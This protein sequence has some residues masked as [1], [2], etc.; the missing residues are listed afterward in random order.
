MKYYFCI[1]G[2]GL[3]NQSLA[4]TKKGATVKSVNSVTGA[5]IT[6][7]PIKS[8][9]QQQNT[10]LHGAIVASSSEDGN[11]LKTNGEEKPLK[12]VKW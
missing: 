7:E 6:N 5:N 9:S 12:Q 3:S 4:G 11:R 8:N 1:T 10:N 2:Q